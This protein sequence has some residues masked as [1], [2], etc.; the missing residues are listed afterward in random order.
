VRLRLVV[1]ASVT[2]LV[3]SMAGSFSG[4]NSRLISDILLKVYKYNFLKP[5][6]P[7]FTEHARVLFFTVKVNSL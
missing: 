4:L 2:A 7:R 6:V 5:P 3:G 1:T